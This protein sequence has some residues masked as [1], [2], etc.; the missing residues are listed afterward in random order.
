MSP[1]PWQGQNLCRQCLAFIIDWRVVR[2]YAH[3]GPT[4][5]LLQTVCYLFLPPPTVENCVCQCSFIF[6][7]FQT[8]CIFY[9]FAKKCVG[10][11]SVSKAIRK[12]RAIF[13]GNNWQEMSLKLTFKLKHFCSIIINYILALTRVIQ[14]LQ[15]KKLHASL[16]HF[17]MPYDPPSLIMLW[18][19]FIEVFDFKTF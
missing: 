13:T 6:C 14:I 17:H 12:A 9:V 8:P 4:T 16:H 7:A 2:G 10:G 3:K 19:I 15:S 11:V 1:F 5:P 18:I